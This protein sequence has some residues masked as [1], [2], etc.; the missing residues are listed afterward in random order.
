MGHIRSICAASAVVVAV[1]VVATPSDARPYR[2]RIVVAE[3]HWGKG[4]VSGPVRA[5]R[6]GW[7]VRLPGGTWV[8]CVRS[9]SDTLRR[10]TVDFWEANG[11]QARNDG[12]NYFRWTWGW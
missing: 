1:A 9:C 7:E 4:T 6:H 8:R 2:E 11:P 3:S 12:P 5:G 10:Q